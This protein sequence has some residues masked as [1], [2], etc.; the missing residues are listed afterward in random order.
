MI[1]N[2]VTID[3]AGCSMYSHRAP[4]EIYF[5]RKIIDPFENLIFEHENNLFS[6]NNH[7]YYYHHYYYD[8]HD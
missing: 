7:Y 5:D 6:N 1:E 2:I 4:I 3:F 8:N